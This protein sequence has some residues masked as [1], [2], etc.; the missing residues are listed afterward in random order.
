MLLDLWRKRRVKDG[1]KTVFAERPGWPFFAVTRDTG[2]SHL[3]PSYTTYCALCQQVNMSHRQTVASA[4]AIGRTEV[5]EKKTR[6]GHI[7]QILSA[8]VPQPVVS[9]H[10]V[11]SAAGLP[12]CDPCMHTCP[13]LPCTHTTR[14]R[15]GMVLHAR[16]HVTDGIEQ[17][18]TCDMCGVTL[19]GSA[20]AKGMHMRNAHGQTDKRSY[21][22][23]HG[24]CDYTATTASNLRKHARRMHS[25]SGMAFECKKCT[26]TCLLREVYVK[27]QQWHNS[28][29]TRGSQIKRL[30][31]TT[32]IQTIIPALGQ[33]GFKDM[34]EEFVGQWEGRGLDLQAIFTERIRGDDNV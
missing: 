32:G 13:Y 22:C 15:Q 7:I 29:F 28:G 25:G 27:H 21:K 17:T 6:K 30:A 26:F 8:S 2:V 14:T 20:I 1:S 12:L 34:G 31:S 24:M 11:L 4:P 10:L 3:S 18:F 23:S 5:V 16:M 9:G 19:R 33:E